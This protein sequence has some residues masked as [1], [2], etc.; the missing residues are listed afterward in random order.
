MFFF[1]LS[2]KKYYPIC[3]SIVTHPLKMHSPCPT[4]ES[5]NDGGH[6]ILDPSGKCKHLISFLQK[7]HLDMD[8]ELIGQIYGCKVMLIWLER[9]TLIFLW[10]INTNFSEYP[11]F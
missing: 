3:L 2:L 1:F 11:G 9:Q 6:E 4:V 10:P 7:N 5:T 8:A